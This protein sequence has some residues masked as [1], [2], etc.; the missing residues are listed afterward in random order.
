MEP[1][2]HPLLLEL[3]PPRLDRSANQL[4]WHTPFTQEQMQTLV[5]ALMA[6]LDCQLGNMDQGADRLFWPV[7]FE[8]VS[9]GL[10]FEALCDSL[11]LQAQEGDSEG[12][13]VLSFLGRLAGE[14]G[15]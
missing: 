7:A 12:A 4:L 5:P 2:A 3:T 13:E 9:L 6:R 10:H 1:L 14:V 8:G 11:W 15:Q